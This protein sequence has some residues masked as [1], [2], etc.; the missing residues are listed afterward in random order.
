MFF[1][2][3]KLIASVCNPLFWITILLLYAWLKKKRRPVVI[4]GLLLYFFSNSFILDEAMRLWEIPGVRTD[5]LE[6]RYDVG[7]VLSGMVGFDEQLE[8]IGFHEN[9]D[10][11]L[12]AVDLYKK[13][14]ID[15]ILISGGSGSLSEKH[16][17]AELL[18]NYFTGLGIPPKDLL[19][20]NTSRNTHENAVNTAKILKE[21]WPEGKFLLITSATHMR[22]ARACFENEG[23]EI[24]SFTTNR[25][26]GLRKYYP[27]HLLVPSV[28]ALG[29]WENLM[30]EWVGYLTYATMGYL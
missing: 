16:S 23:I 29:G 7:I 2:I 24:F 11:M 19:T 20:E 30:H 18:F 8:R 25:H 15:K 21:H 9:I 22:R 6:T 1:V 13:G 10:R 4:A 17:E 14:I 3:S 27:D 28:H 5:S 26:S 12:Q